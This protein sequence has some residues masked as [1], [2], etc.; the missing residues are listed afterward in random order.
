[1]IRCMQYFHKW[2]TLIIS[3]ALV[4]QKNKRN[5]V[6]QGLRY[7][8]LGGICVLFFI[9]AQVIEKGELKMAL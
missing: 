4:E 3:L 9:N 2:K 8:Y 7:L 1:M 5:T 6:K